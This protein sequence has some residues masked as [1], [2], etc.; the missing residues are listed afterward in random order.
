MKTFTSRLKGPG[1]GAVKKNTL[2]HP[3][4]LPAHFHFSFLWEFSTQLLPRAKSLS[5]LSSAVRIRLLPIWGIGVLSQMS[6][7]T[8]FDT[9][10]SDVFD[11]QITRLVFFLLRNRGWRDSYFTFRDKIEI[12][13]PS[14]SFLE[15]R[16]RI[17]S[18]I[19]SGFK[20]RSRICSIKS[21]ISRRGLEIKR[22]AR[23]RARIIIVKSQ[24]ILR[25]CLWFT[26]SIS[27]GKT[28][29]EISHNTTQSYLWVLIIHG[30]YTNIEV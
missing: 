3:K 16:T 9:S 28:F 10:W 7:A 29:S 15:T 2:Y 24:E 27:F 25:K 23:V 5:T 14:V 4:G 19:I 8:A 26:I 20:T 17:F 12:L 30:L 1:G 11:F 13:F 18:L 22:I 21:W 6:M